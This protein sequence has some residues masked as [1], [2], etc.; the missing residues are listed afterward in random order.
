MSTIL[1]FLASNPTLSI[2]IL[3]V[4]L[5]LLFCTILTVWF[6]NAINPTIFYYLS[7]NSHKVGR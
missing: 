7:G 1:S 5:I 3:I 4:A 6:G 2:V